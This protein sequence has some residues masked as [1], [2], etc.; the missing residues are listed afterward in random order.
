MTF[1]RGACTHPRCMPGGC[2][3]CS[4]LLS[5][6]LLFQLHAHHLQT[7]I[8]SKRLTLSTSVE[9][10]IYHFVRYFD[11]STMLGRN[12]PG[13]PARKTCDRWSA[14]WLWIL[15]I[16]LWTCKEMGKFLMAKS[17]FLLLSFWPLN[18]DR[19]ELVKCASSFVSSV[20]LIFLYYFGAPFASPANNLSFN[21]FISV[22][23]AKYL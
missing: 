9:P 21:R 23:R 7:I 13:S 11:V 5:L 14:N 6:F 1:L 3:I 12:S 17:D 18:P 2:C 16:H 22:F 10:S 20:I 15:V 4:V 19:S 8:I